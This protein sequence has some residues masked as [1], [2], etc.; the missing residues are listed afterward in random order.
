MRHSSAATAH[1]QSV[2]D[3]RQLRILRPGRLSMGS[4]T[5]TTTRTSRRNG[6]RTFPN[7]SR[8]G[9]ETGQG[10]TSESLHAV[11]CFATRL[12]GSE[13]RD[14]IDARSD[15]RRVANNGGGQAK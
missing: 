7:T 4:S 13:Q 8:M 3:T 9:T 12:G 1:G 11:A 5:S 6:N 10:Y 15:R 14:W 2:T